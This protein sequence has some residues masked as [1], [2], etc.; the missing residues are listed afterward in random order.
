MLSRYNI[1]T[2]GALLLSIT[3]IARIKNWVIEFAI[4]ILR[5]LIPK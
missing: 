3:V 2:E 4:F 1:Y 5:E